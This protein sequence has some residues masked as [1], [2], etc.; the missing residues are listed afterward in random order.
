MELILIDFL[1][2]AI[3]DSTYEQ[4]PAES[5]PRMRYE[6]GSHKPKQS[7]S[8]HLCNVNELIGGYSQQGR[9][10]HPASQE[11]QTNGETVVSHSQVQHQTGSPQRTNHMQHSPH[12]VMPHINMNSHN[13]INSNHVIQSNGYSI[14]QTPEN[15]S[16]PNQMQQQNH[17]QRPSVIESN[18]PQIIEC[19]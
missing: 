1:V 17:E 6:M 13:V 19:T 18:Q 4:D 16:H 2:C 7:H 12:S 15:R 8:P 5:S 3:T 11:L 10:I 14:N 9:V